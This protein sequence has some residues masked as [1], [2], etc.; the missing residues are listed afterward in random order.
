MSRNITSYVVLLI[1]HIHCMLLS[2]HHVHG[3]DVRTVV[4]CQLTQEI[5]AAKKQKICHQ[6][7]FATTPDM[8]QRCLSNSITLQL[9]LLQHMKL[10]PKCQHT[11]AS[12]STTL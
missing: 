1:A 6:A 8:K 2:I 11:Y 9:G 10:A 7:I 12:S 3:A 5:S 4:K